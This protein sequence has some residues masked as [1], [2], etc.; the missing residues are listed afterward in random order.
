MDEPLLQSNL[1]EVAWQAVPSKTPSP[2]QRHLHRESVEINVVLAG[3]VRLTIDGVEHRLGKGDVYVIWP[4]SV[5][6]DIETD[7]DAEV[8]VVRAPSM[9]GDKFAAPG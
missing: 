8:L 4:E 1:V 6:G 9:P 7:A 2:D 5:V 3:S